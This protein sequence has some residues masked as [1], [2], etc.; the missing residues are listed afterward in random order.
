MCGG[1]G[2]TTDYEFSSG[3]MENA[4]V[5]SLGASTVY[6]IQMVNNYLGSVAPAIWTRGDDAY[7]FNVNSEGIQW[8]KIYNG[9][10]ASPITSQPTAPTISPSS[11]PTFEPTVMDPTKSPTQR[12]TRYPTRCD[13]DGDCGDGFKCELVEYT[14]QVVD[15][16]NNG[17]LNGVS[18]VFQFVM[19]LLLYFT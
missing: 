15:L 16:I 7:L 4:E 9:P 10:T 8:T 14:C 2:R 17:K 1:R 12:P 3:I 18:V 5:V 19:A 6:Q 13:D 11:M